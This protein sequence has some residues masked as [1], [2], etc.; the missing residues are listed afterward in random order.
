[1]KDKIYFQDRRDAALNLI[2][3]LPIGKMKL[4]KWIVL[5][6]SYGGYNIAKE[7]A[8]ELNAPLDMIFCDKIYTPNNKDCE[9]AIVT[10]SEELVIY[11]EL[12]K[13]FEIS[14]DFIFS[15]SKYVHENLLNKQVFKFRNGKKL[16]ELENKNILLV[17]EGLNTSLTIMACI[18]TAINLG[19]KSVS[20][21][22]PIIPTASIQV[23][24]SIADDLYY[25]K[26]IDHFIEIGHY[27]E[28]L[29]Q[30]TFQDLINIK[31]G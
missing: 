24:E 7:I 10:E 31:K 13:S 19:A 23:V 27:Y 26:K 16:S 1:M 9:I 8:K 14:L 5:S 4:E 18:K 11:E 28:E 12:A 25:V 21:A 2:D 20:V 22:V 6:A 30:I 3:I 15:K 29:E 17:D